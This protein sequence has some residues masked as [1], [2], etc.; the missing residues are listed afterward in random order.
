MPKN[1]DDLRL[2][3]REYMK[4]LGVTDDMADEQ[5]YLAYIEDNLK[6]Q[7]SQTKQETSA[8]SGGTTAF[9]KLNTSHLSPIRN[10]AEYY[11]RKLNKIESHN[12]GEVT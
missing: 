9:S 5:V 6:A 4:N 1:L 8:V 10:L 7:K 2:L 11:Q 3:S 12:T